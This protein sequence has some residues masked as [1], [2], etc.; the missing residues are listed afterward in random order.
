MEEVAQGGAYSGAP[1]N[2]P[3]ELY[4]W[5]QDIG[6]YVGGYCSEECAYYYGVEVCCI[7]VCG[8]YIVL[9]TSAK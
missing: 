8:G 5:A 6:Y 2:R 3:I 4:E 9:L 1:N 7:V